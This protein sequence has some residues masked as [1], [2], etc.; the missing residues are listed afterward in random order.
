MKKKI[1]LDFDPQATLLE[2][3]FFFDDEL[4]AGYNERLVAVHPVMFERDSAPSNVKDPIKICV[5]EVC[6]TR[7]LY[8]AG[9]FNA[10]AMY[11]T[12]SLPHNEH[13]QWYLDERDRLLKAAC[14]KGHEELDRCESEDTTD[15]RVAGQNAFYEYLYSRG[16]AIRI[17]ERFLTKVDILTIQKMELASQDYHNL[18]LMLQLET[19]MIADSNLPVFV[20]EAQTM[21]L[22]QRQRNIRYYQEGKDDTSHLV[23]CF[24][25]ALASTLTLFGQPVKFEHIVV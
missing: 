15:Y 2:V 11:V 17:L 7:E 1:E 22:Q 4:P 23:E 13:S 3:A 5:P 14:T 10:L 18:L 6:T 9:A 20:Q 8:I 19:S 16:E 12:E 21:A 24:K 25:T